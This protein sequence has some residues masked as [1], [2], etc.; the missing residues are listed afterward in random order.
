MNSLSQKTSGI[1][2]IFNTINRKFYIGSAMNISK[3]W[4]EH[5]RALRKN[6]HPN[7]HLQNAWNFYGEDAFVFSVLEICFKSMLLIREQYYIDS[8]LP[9]YNILKTAGSC[10]GLKHSPETRAKISDAGMGRKNA[11]G[12]KHS[13]ETRQ[14]MSLAKRG[15]KLS[16]MAC[17][18]RCNIVVS[19]VARANMSI[20]HCKP[21]SQYTLNLELIKEYNSISVA[22]EATGAKKIGSC[23][24][25]KLNS[26]G[27]FIWRYV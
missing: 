6:K 7:K 23:C 13:S 2:K 11:L 12:Y 25:G 15:C 14:K 21:V 3:R 24:S 8:L 27:G 17:A 18:K 10:F 19:Q 1:Y 26:S 20:A 5:L 16:P 4:G 22:R 9:E